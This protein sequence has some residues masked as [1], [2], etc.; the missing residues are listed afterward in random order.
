MDDFMLRVLMYAIGYIVAILVLLL[1]TIIG[2]TLSEKLDNGW[3]MLIS[4]LVGYSIMAGMWMVYEEN[5]LTGTAEV[6]GMEYIPSHE[7]SGIRTQPVIVDG[8]TSIITMP[9]SEYKE[10]AYTIHVR[11]KTDD[12]YKRLHLEVSESEYES[13]NIG[14]EIELSDY[15]KYN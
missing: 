12:S 3:V 5:E 7:K 6:I 10:D 15:E 4:M 9:T 13:F 2:W 1:P 14:D 8:K 11:K